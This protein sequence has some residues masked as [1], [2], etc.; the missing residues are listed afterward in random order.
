M[1]TM[2][3]T[4]VVI[5]SNAP[6]MGNYYKPTP[7][8]PRSTVRGRVIYADTGRAVRRAGLMLMSAR[9]AGS[10]E[11]SGLT[12][13]RGE[14]EIK[15]VTEG[16]YFISVSTPGVLTPFS[17]VGSLDQIR[18]DNFAAMEAEVSKDFQEVVV[19]GI[20]DADVI[21]TVKRGAAITGRIMYADG[22]EAAGVRVE[23]LRKKDGQYSP[24]ITSLGDIFGAMFGGASGGMR[25]DD[26]GVFRVAGLPAGDYIVRAVEN[27]SHTEKTNRRGDDEFMAII[28]FNPSSM[29]ATYYPNTSDA[30]KAEIIKVALGQ[31]TAE[32]NITLP[33]RELHDLKG[34]ALNKATREPLKNVEITLKSET[35]IASIFGAESESGRKI[36][37]DEKGRW[38]YKQLP[39]GK[40]TLT[41]KPQ[42][43]ESTESRNSQK[44][45]PPKFAQT[46][47][48]IVIE[49]KDGDDITV[50]LS[51]GASISGTIAFDSGQPFA[52]PIFV[53]ASDENGKFS[54][55]DYVGSP[56][57]DDG[58]AVAKKTQEF[59]IEGVPAGKIF[60]NSSS[61]SETDAAQQFYV[62]SILYG[63]RD[64][65][66]ATLETKEG[67]EIKGVQIVLSRDVGKLK[68]AVVNADKSAAAG[69]R[70][71]LVPTD[72]RLWNNSYANIYAQTNSDGE[73]EIA[74]APGEYFIVFYNEENYNSKEEDAGKTLTQR[75]RESLERQTADASKVT[76]KAKETEKI[77]LTLPAGK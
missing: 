38:S 70:F 40:Y 35:N 3:N 23:I 76:I 41:A 62:K 51:Y 67:E 2:S 44:P 5:N 34:V 68:G 29:V 17:A 77:T 37:T 6:M 49:D 11:A 61:T 10:R 47:K 56:Y 19:N 26:R 30:K 18:P 33:D 65:G 58:K 7:E 21:V 13:E 1:T 9:G 27:V 52:Q 50:E 15:G 64:I 72:K 4:A 71:W 39:A 16:R 8:P 25:T 69:A 12:N 59:K 55:S 32:I 28:G 53:V 54:A 24:V 20:N 42:E 75:T 31:E 63:G 73:F 60:V 74:G 46:Q 36:T 66:R 45:K 57:G 43:Y 14:F 22:T 48:E